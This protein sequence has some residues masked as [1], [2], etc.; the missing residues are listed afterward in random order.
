MPG[1][2]S[3]TVPGLPLDET[4]PTHTQMNGNVKHESLFG[5][6]QKYNRGRATTWVFGL[7]QRGT[8]T[9]RFFLISDR[10]NSTLIPLIL[11]NMK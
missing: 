5:K 1:R 4:L 7:A 8:R 11:K 3:A 6:K 2:G 9:C 10:R